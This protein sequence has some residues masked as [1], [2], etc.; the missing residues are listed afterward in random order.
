M[1]LSAIRK[2]CMKTRSIRLFDAAAERIIGQMGIDDIEDGD[3]E[4]V[5][6]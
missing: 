6:A 3:G 5:G 1:N 4:E 2:L